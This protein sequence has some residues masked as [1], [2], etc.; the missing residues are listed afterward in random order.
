[1]SSVDVAKWNREFTGQ[2]TIAI[3]A[4][5][6]TLHQACQILFENI[7]KRTP[8]GNPALWNWPAH[9]DY[10]PGTLKASWEIIINGLDVTIQNLQPYAYRVETGYS[11]QAPAGMMR[12]S[13][14]E[15]Q[16]ILNEVQ[17]RNGE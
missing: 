16:S 4:S 14:I 3:K 17:K 11:T 9:K 7:V 6:R 1:M 5:E 13:L 8:V 2:C 12:I 15:F 10:I